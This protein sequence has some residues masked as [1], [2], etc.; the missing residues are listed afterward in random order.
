MNEFQS[1]STEELKQIE[2]GDAPS[3]FGQAVNTIVGAVV[4]AV[5][6]AVDAIVSTARAYL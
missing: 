1:V 6:K 3:Q 4:G 5:T 2:G